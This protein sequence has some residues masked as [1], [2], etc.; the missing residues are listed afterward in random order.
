MLKIDFEE[1]TP[2]IFLP[3]MHGSLNLSASSL[4]F[5]RFSVV[6]LLFRCIIRSL[7]ARVN[8]NNPDKILFLLSFFF[9][10]LLVSFLFFYPSFVVASSGSEN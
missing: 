8:F 7:V 6:F 2:P 4:S 3:K 1:D 5:L 10:V 9:F